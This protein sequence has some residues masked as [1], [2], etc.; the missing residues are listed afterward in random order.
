VADAK[1]T[2]RVQ[3]VADLADIK[4]GMG[5]L[6]GELAAVKKAASTGANGVG[7]LNQAAGELKGLFSGL[8]VAAVVAGI[9]AIGS[10]ALASADALGKLSQKTGA[11]VQTLS[12]LR[13]AVHGSEEDMAQLEKALIALA[14][15]QDDAASGNKEAAAAFKRLGISMADVKSQDPGELFKQIAEKFG[16]M[17]SGAQK[18]AVAQA[19]FGKSGTELIPILNELANGGFSEAEERAKKLGLYLSQD[20]VDAAAQGKDA[21]GDMK[22]VAEGMATS[23][24]N[25]VAPVVTQAMADIANS[26]DTEGSSVLERLGSLAAG[27]LQILISSFKTV[28]ETIAV[29]LAMVTQGANSWGEIIK[30]AVSGDFSGAKDAF[31]EGRRRQRAILDGY[32]ADLLAEWGENGAVWRALAG[33]TTKPQAEGD[34]GGGTGTDGSGSGDKV[35]K[36]ILNSA[37]L[38]RDAI[39]RELK[40]LDSLFAD[41]LVSIADYYA[42]KR[43]LQEASIDAQIAEAQEQA[44]SAKSSEEQGR[45]LTK[46]VEL[47]RDRAEI[48]PA[49]ARE[50]AKAEADLAKQLESVRAELQALDGFS[51]EAVRQRLEQQYKALTDKLK[52]ESDTAGLAMVE[53][54]INR[55]VMQE[56]L[57]AVQ[58]DVSAALSRLQTTETS[59]ASQVEAGL[60]AQSTGEERLQQ[61]REET[62][63]Q[64]YEARARTLAFLA[65]MDDQTTPEAAKA[66]EYLERLNGEIAGVEASKATLLGLNRGDVQDQAQNSLSNFFSDLATGAK[67][68]KD[69]FRDLVLSFVQ[70]LARMAAEALAKRFIFSLFGSFGSGGGV[71]GIGSGGAGIGGGLLGGIGGAIS[72]HTGGIVGGTGRTRTFRWNPS[73]AIPRMHVGGIAGLGPNEVPA[74]LERDEEVITRQDRRH[75]WNG[76][77]KGGG[78]GRDK[79]PILVMGERQLADALASTA[80][81]DVVITHVR[82]NWDSL[83]GGGR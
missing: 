1:T 20:L 11:S 52:A 14:K 24:A 71:G 46:I 67:N 7:L 70:G 4:Q 83:S 37:E 6:R 63:R 40:A 59:V 58:S 55:K 81:E 34:T 38:A 73:A 16:D 53:K 31:A 35:V 74:I 56:Q 76:G 43:Q 50:Q 82:N 27:T 3:I 32:K 29:G 68:L 60:L 19:I 62:L 48:G 77:G 49:L 51:D 44:K 72:R 61:V 36:G 8:G 26:V 54:L 41:G 13:V 65:S 80:G 9:G 78:R 64:L 2:L 5:L 25:Q 30:K 45:A 10:N 28:G 12:V 22:L 18:A 33:P 42:K 47:Q 57:N 15:R 66:L 69:A 79:Q 23:F 17:E 21:L 39:D 75:R